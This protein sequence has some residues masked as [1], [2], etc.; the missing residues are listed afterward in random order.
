[1]AGQLQGKIIAI[2]GAGS[3]IALAT[4]RECAKR[5]ASGLSL[6]DINEN[7][8]NRAVDEIKNANI[9]AK[10]EIFGKVV[11]VSK[12]DQ[13]DSWIAETIEKFGKIDCAAN[14]AGV[15]GEPGGK[16]FKKHR[17]YHG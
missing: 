15:E 17:G 8:I 16:V 5:G 6:C 3:G 12:S 11:D 10:V 7:A 9:D 13:V 1:M 14:I 2:T 4:A